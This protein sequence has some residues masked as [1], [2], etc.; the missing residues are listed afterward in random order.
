VKFTSNP[1]LPEVVLTQFFCPDDEHD[2]L[3]TLEL[4][5]KINA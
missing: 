2:V 4:K 5:I 3:K 1:Q